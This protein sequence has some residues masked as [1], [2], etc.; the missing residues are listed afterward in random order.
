MYQHLRRFKPSHAAAGQGRPSGTA[1]QARRMLQSLPT[2]PEASA[3]LRAD[4]CPVAEDSLIAASAL[5]AETKSMTAGSQS[6]SSAELCC[7]TADGGDVSSKKRKVSDAGHIVRPVSTQVDSQSIE[8]CSTVQPSRKRKAGTATNI[9]IEKQQQPVQ[10]PQHA[11]GRTIFAQSNI[12]QKQPLQTQHMQHATAESPSQHAAGRTTIAQ[13][14]IEQKLP[15][16]AQ[17]VQHGESQLQ[18]RSALASSQVAE[19]LG[20]SDMDRQHPVDSI[21]AHR[22]A[23]DYMVA[24]T[25]EFEVKRSGHEKT[26]WKPYSVFDNAPEV[27]LAYCQKAGLQLSEAFHRYHL[28]VPQDSKDAA[29]QGMGGSSNRKRQLD[30][31]SRQNAVNASAK[32]H[33]A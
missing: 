3:T 27:M 10:I 9:L 6:V 13:I 18:Q 5:S 24:R 14:N 1:K 11:A 22:P 28:Q 7:S 26:D 8:P 17:H 4:Q 30:V 16:Q 2:V 19:D 25:K 31:K 23:N 29:Q 33:K 32:R 15:L 12:N 20:P 21:L